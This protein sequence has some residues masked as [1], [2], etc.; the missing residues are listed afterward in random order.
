[1]TTTQLVGGLYRVLLFLAAG[2]SSS[3]SE[4]ELRVTI[5]DSVPSIIFQSLTVDQTYTGAGDVLSFPADIPVAMGA[6]VHTVEFEARQPTSPGLVTAV[7]GG[8]Q[9]FRAQ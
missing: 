1:M 4:I 9:L 2:G 3:N 5:S 8:I 6:L 7:A